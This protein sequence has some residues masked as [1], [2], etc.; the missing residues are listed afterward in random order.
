MRSFLHEFAYTHMCVWGGVCVKYFNIFR[1]AF[2][3]ECTSTH[4]K[5]K[6]NSRVWRDED[7]SSLDRSF[8]F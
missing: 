1:Q 6:K 4:D 2:L 7:V 5:I 8:F 3:R